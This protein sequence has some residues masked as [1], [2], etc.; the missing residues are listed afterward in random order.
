MLEYSRDELASPLRALDKVLAAVESGAFDPDTTRSG[1]WAHGPETPVRLEHGPAS[2][3]TEVVGSSPAK[4]SSSSGSDTASEVVDTEESSGC[5]DRAADAAVESV[6]PADPALLPSI[7]DGGL[8]R[9]VAS[10]F[11]HGVRVGDLDR[12]LCGRVFPKRHHTLDAW[13]SFVGPLCR[14]CFPLKID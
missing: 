7:P 1:Y 9:N 11:L 8:V 14:D 3:T 6:A 5:E 2:A 13:P 4:D 10:K 12:L